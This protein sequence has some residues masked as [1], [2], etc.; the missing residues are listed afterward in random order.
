MPAPTPL[1]EPFPVSGDAP[2]CCG[3]TQAPHHMRPNGWMIPVRRMETD[4]KQG[5]FSENPKKSLV[6]QQTDPA[7][8]RRPDAVDHASGGKRG[9]AFQIDHRTNPGRVGEAF[10]SNGPFRLGSQQPCWGDEPSKGNPAA[11]KRLL[12]T[13]QE[14]GGLGK[15][16]IMK[17]PLTRRVMA[18]DQT[19]CHPLTLLCCPEM[20][21]T[22]EHGFMPLGDLF[23]EPGRERGI[24]IDPTP[25]V[26]IRYHQQR[27]ERHAHPG[28]IIQHGG[29]L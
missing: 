21:I 27:G 28:K 29:D 9:S 7:S 2:T 23:P 4:A 3:Q 26:M 18:S 1:V 17:F 10:L 8:P 22:V 14:F 15:R 25:M 6:P 24:L 13:P 20:V 11:E 5:N 16:E 12:A 19:C